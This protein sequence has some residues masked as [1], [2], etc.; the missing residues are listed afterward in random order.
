M[1]HLFLFNVL[2]IV[3]LV[4]VGCSEEIPDND[5]EAEESSFSVYEDSKEA[6]E[7]I[8]ELGE[9]SEPSEEYQIGVV[10]KTLSNEH[11]KEMKNGYEDAAEEYGVKIDVQ[12]AETEDDL[13]GQL[14]IA[15]T[16][17]NKDYDAI[18]ISPLSQSN[19]ESAINLAKEK[20]VPVLN[21]DDSRVEDVDVFVGGDH[22]E[23]ANMAA[24]YME[25]NVDEDAD[26]A[27]IEGQS[28]SP[29]AELRSSGFE[30]TVEK[31]DNL[32]LEASQSADWDRL[33]ALDTTTNI[34]TSNPDIK[35]F[36]ANNDTMALGVVEALENENALDD[37][38]VIG[39]DGDPDA[40]QSIEDE[41][42]TATVATFPYEMGFT[43]TEMAIYLLEGEEIPNE[44]IS[45]QLIIDKE[46]KEEHFPD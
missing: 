24:E 27:Q 5:G 38:M 28:G 3:T 19:L 41:K 23:L 14:S 17:L 25:D 8:E 15:E 22:S 44:V 2:L 30:D 11:W 45:K 40:I 10:L 26:V 16:M 4:L 21:V 42:L 43:A 12:A 31:S 39:T 13:S 32:S 6:D 7:V 36:Y 20:D 1:K 37:T 18:A 9:L 34:L 29:A 35:A 46:N 33:E